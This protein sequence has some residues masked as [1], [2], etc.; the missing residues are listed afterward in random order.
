MLFAQFF[1]IF[2]APLFIAAS[3]EI[4][5]LNHFGLT[6]TST[7]ILASRSDPEGLIELVRHPASQEYLSYHRDVF[8]NIDQPQDRSSNPAFH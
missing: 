5:A 2:F 3:T 6:F 8:R 4:V 7:H 1:C